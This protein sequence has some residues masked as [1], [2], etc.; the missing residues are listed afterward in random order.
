MFSYA[1]LQLRPGLAARG[2]NLRET[3]EGIKNSGSQNEKQQHEMIKQRQIIIS[4]NIMCSRVLRSHLEPCP[5][6]TETIIRLIG[7]RGLK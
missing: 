4:A 3:L 5:L 6:S 1:S 2:S 7:T